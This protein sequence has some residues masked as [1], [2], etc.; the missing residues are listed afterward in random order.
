[1]CGPEVPPGG[2]VRTDGSSTTGSLWSLP[3]T[4]SMRSSP[5]SIADT[6]TPGKSCV[7]R[8]LGAPFRGLSAGT[9]GARRGHVGL[10]A[11]VVLLAV[12]AAGRHC[13][14]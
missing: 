10:S 1:M 14:P 6:P 13:S 8:R 5:R 4:F 11:V 9:D 12:L 2:T 3:W 7:V